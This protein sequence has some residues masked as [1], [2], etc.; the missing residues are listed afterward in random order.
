[1]DTRSVV[2]AFKTGRS[3]NPTTHG[4]QVTHFELQVDQ[5]FWLSLRWVPTAENQ[6]ADAI[7]RP[8]R[9]EII[10]LQPAVFRRSRDFFREF[11]VDLRAT[12][13]KAQEG[14]RRGRPKS[15]GCSSFRCTTAKSRRGW[16]SLVKTRPLHQEE[17]RQRLCTGSRPWSWRGMSC[18]I[19]PSIEHTPRMLSLTC[20][21]TCS[22]RS[23]ARR[24]GS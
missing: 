2:D 11:T 6:S 7:I 13:E 3:I 22:R 10:R 20:A 19:W 23:A 16:T 14:P 5:G 8:G 4:L 18:N 17:N 1:M 12:F 9:A 24:Y 21:N 15:G